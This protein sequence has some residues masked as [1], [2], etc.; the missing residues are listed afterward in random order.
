MFPEAFVAEVVKMTLKKLQH[1]PWCTD[2]RIG[3]VLCRRDV[4]PRGRANDLRLLVGGQLCSRDSC[5]T[6]SPPGVQETQ[7]RQ[8]EEEDETTSLSREGSPVGHCVEPVGILT[9]YL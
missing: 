3:R 7:N 2:R 1:C 5:M 6:C 8:S 4:A 9:Q